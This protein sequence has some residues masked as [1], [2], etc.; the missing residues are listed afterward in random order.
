MG[1][2]LRITFADFWQGFK[3]EY[4][5]IT[6]ILSKEYNV[7]ID[8]DNPQVVFCSSLHGMRN[9]NKY[10]QPKILYTGEN[11]KMDNYNVYASM[12]FDK[13][14]ETNYH[15]P[16][17]QLECM[18]HG[19]Y[20]PKLLNRS[21]NGLKIGAKFCS[22]VVS[23]PRSQAR[24]EIFKQL[25]LLKGVSVNSYGRHN[26]NTDGMINKGH[27]N[28]LKFLMNN[29]HVFN[30]AFET[31][32]R[33]GYCTEKIIH[34]YLVGSIPIYHGDPLVHTYFNPNS[35]INGN[36]K[37]ME[38]VADIIQRVRTRRGVVN[39]IM[40]EPVFTDKQYKAMINN[41]NKLEPWLLDKVK[42]LL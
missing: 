30:V 36:G 2:D 15:L 4:D 24:N 38:E 27:P 19:D 26:H 37:S 23:N 22:Y 8:N 1:K 6:P 11:H 28:K 25:N 42:E 14:S 41:I 31:D 3:P 7:V 34:A 18:V 9:A 17:W 13:H 39:K 21:K 16:L 33:E 40:N 12:S 5:F 32:P 29:P 35:F 20:I 10:S